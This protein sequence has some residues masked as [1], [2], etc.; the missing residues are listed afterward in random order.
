[1]VFDNLKKTPH[2]FMSRKKKHIPV[3]AF[4]PVEQLSSFVETN[5]E[6]RKEDLLIRMAGKINDSLVQLVRMVSFHHIAKDNEGNL[7]LV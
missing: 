3:P 5:T 7:S 1:M 4:I 6:L 2:P